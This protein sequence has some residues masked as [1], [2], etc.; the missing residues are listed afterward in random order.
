M[1]ENCS[2]KTGL[3]THYCRKDV[4]ICIVTCVIYHF[5]VILK[6]QCKLQSK[7]YMKRVLKRKMSFVLFVCCVTA[8]LASKIAP[9]ILLVQFESVLC[10]HY[11]VKGSRTLFY[12]SVYYTL[13]EVSDT[14][15]QRSTVKQCPKRL[16]FQKCKKSHQTPTMC[17]LSN[18]F[19]RISTI[20]DTFSPIHTVL[21]SL[22]RM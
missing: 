19:N 1:T 17:R 15:I 5:P 4:E 20:F 7:R 16:L 9:K 3:F 14:N 8:A 11:A 2:I 18:H 22:S 12:K 6:E 10:C 21:C 13:Q